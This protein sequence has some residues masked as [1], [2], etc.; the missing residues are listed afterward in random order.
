MKNSP[1]GKL[2]FRFVP[3]CFDS[4]AQSFCRAMII[5]RCNDGVAAKKQGERKLAAKLR[6]FI[7][8]V[9]FH[10]ILVCFSKKKHDYTGCLYQRS[11]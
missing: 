1:S 4:D 6:D 2:Y 8:S 7:I 11:A 3:F 9:V 5:I 10:F